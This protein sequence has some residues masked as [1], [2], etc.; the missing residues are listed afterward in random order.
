MVHVNLPV[1]RK[2]T[3]RLSLGTISDREIEMGQE[4]DHEKRMLAYSTRTETEW[5]NTASFNLRRE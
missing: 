1:L 3:L 4:M 5:Q 2:S